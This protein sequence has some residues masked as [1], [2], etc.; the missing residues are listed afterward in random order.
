M[1]KDELRKDIRAKRCELDE[2]TVKNSG[3][4]IWNRLKELKEFKN[5]INI[6][7]NR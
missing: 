1:N 3:T 6:K 5:S 7:T 4:T 2:N